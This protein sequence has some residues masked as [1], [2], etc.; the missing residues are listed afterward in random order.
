MVNIILEIIIILAY[1]LNVRIGAL[2]FLLFSIATLRDKKYPFFDRIVKILIFSLPLS[3]ISVLGE[4]LPHALSWYNIFLF[5]FLIYLCIKAG[6]KVV[7]KVAS[8]SAI[9]VALLGISILGTIDFYKS[10]I[11]VTQIMLMV[12]PLLVVYKS[13]INAKNIKNL[14]NCYRD[15]CVS[16]A[17]CMLIQLIAFNHFD[18]I[19]GTVNLYAQRVSCS[20]LFTGA[21]ILPIFIG[22]GLVISLIDATMGVDRMFNVLCATIMLSSV[23]LNTSRSALFALIIT[24]F[25]ILFSHLRRLKKKIDGRLL[26][27]IALLLV[28]GVVYQSVTRIGLSSF[29]DDNGRYETWANGYN[30]W[31]SSIKNFLFGGG[32]ASNEWNDAVL[33]HNM[34]I[35]SLAQTGLIF[36]LSMIIALAKY[37]KE[38]RNKPHFPVIIFLLLSGMLVTDFYANAFITIAFIYVQLSRNIEACND[39]K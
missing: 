23:V 19:L 25:Y 4:S 27:F 8:I 30:I 16:T 32:F 37:M 38:N 24:V 2:L 15:V 3:Y 7:R 14:S 6:H 21:S 36:T 22:V 5:V 39:K 1:F 13:K 26:L 31:T 35:Q 20:V 28:V 34:L 29:L 9:F 11:E 33:P 12:V 18:T 10:I 17:I